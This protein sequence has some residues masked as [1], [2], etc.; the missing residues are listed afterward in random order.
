MHA[1]VV[2][3]HR[4]RTRLLHD[5]CELVAEQP[6]TRT[7]GRSVR[8]RREVDVVT[9]R[10]R[11]GRDARRDVAVG[12]HAHAREV[13]TEG[14]FHRTPNGV[15]QRRAAARRALDP[16]GQ[17]VAQVATLDADLGV[18]VPGVT[19]DARSHTPMGDVDARCTAATHPLHDL[20][21]PV[22]DAVGLALIRIGDG[23]DRQLRLADGEHG[24]PR[25]AHPGV[26]ARVPERPWTSPAPRRAPAPSVAPAR[27]QPVLLFSRTR[28]LHHEAC[29]FDGDGWFLAG[30]VTQPRR[31]RRRSPR[32]GGTRRS[33]SASAGGPASDTR[34]RRPGPRTPS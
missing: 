8:P 27:T 1:E 5:M 7:V 19:A 6:H 10:E 18:L 21:H 32:V 34:G 14:R 13:G 16:G 24:A 15:G 29:R 4:R 20:H 3:G 11:G 28:T 23:P 2:V 25:L 17:F 12:V 33:R 30:C 9:H 22:G 31:A 26:D